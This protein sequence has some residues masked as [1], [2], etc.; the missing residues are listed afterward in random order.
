M[1][2]RGVENSGTKNTRTLDI[3]L[4]GL[5]GLQ[6]HTLNGTHVIQGGAPHERSEGDRTPQDARR[7]ITRKH[8]WSVFS[9]QSVAPVTAAVHTIAALGDSLPETTISI[10][11]DKPWR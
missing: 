10:L 6:Q 4:Q 11:P 9:R 3:V 8:S 5:N 7:R 2:Y 1:S